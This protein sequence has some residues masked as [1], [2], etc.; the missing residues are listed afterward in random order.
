MLKL[1][2]WTRMAESEVH[3]LHENPDLLAIGV[4]VCSWFVLVSAVTGQ[5]DGHHRLRLGKTT[6]SVSHRS[7]T[8]LSQLYL[9]FGHFG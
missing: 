2:S 5:N 7:N 6:S 4:S 8:G 1:V 3:S 9:G